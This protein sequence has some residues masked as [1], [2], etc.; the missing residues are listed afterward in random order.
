MTIITTTSMVVKRIYERVYYDS[1][2]D[3]VQRIDTSHMTK[4]T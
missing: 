3:Y 1:E 4:I 2:D